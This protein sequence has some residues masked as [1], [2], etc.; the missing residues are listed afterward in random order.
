MEIT[1]NK[2]K[3]GMIMG[4]LIGDALGSQYEF[5]SKNTI[6]QKYKEN[7]NMIDFFTTPNYIFIPSSNIIKNTGELSDDGQLIMALIHHL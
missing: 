5:Y 3:L 2:R 6:K 7:N 1:I 4:A